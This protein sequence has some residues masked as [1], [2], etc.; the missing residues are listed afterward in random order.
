MSNEQEPRRQFLRRMLA[1]VPTAAIGT[2]A[3][4]S[5]IGCKPSSPAALA[6]A[7]ARYTPEFFTADEWRFL[8]AAVNR[9]IPADRLGPGAVEAGVPEFIDRQLETPWGH[10]KLW[11]MHGPFHVQEAPTLGYQ[12]NLA[13][14]DIYR[15]GIEACNGWCHRHYQGKSFADLNKEDQEA[16]LHD[17]EHGK[18]QFDAVPAGTFFSYLLA[19]T[20]EG[21]FAD[22]I[23]GGNKAMAGW[24]TIGFPG[25]RAD[26]ADWVDQNNAKYPYGPVSIDGARG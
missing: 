6:A 17:M 10:G 22:P 8:E 20:K 21:F 19:N 25:A 5:Q 14:R 2:G 12:L 11:Y 4:L 9:L 7:P 16:V 1:A 23:Y 18:A 13:P 24:K 26:F 3:G 15:H